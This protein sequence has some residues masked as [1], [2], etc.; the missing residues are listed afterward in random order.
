MTQIIDGKLIAQQIKDEIKKDTIALKSTTGI[1]PGLAVILV[2]ENPASQTYVG[3]KGKA[4]EE[5][6]FLS[7][8]DRQPSTISE[9]ELLDIVRKY[10][11]RPDIHGILVQLPLPDHIN[12]SKVIETIDYKKDVDG[13]HP[14]NAGKLVIGEPCFAPCTPAGVLVLLE[15]S[16]QLPN[17]KHTVVIGRS[18]IVGK[19]MANLLIQK[20]KNAN[21]TVTICHTGTKN[22]GDFTRQADIIVAA[23]GKVNSVTPDMIK[24]GAVIID[25]GMNRIEDSSK[26][27]G[28]RLVGDVDYDGCFSKSSAITP[29]PGGV[30]PMTIAML[31]KNTFL[32]ATGKIFS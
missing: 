2:G 1:T 25:V 18:N 7:V 24:D 11:E 32:S 12:A 21:S 31:L 20:A 9:N 17:G 4:C 19:P 26:K 22:I 5:V 23:V 3:A 10:N 16:G 15:R 29:V 27:S 28:Y 6:G 8:T 14:I 13:F 30:G